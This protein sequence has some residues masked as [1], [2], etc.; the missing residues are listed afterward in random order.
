M[1]LV[2]TVKVGKDFYVNDQRWL[3]ESADGGEMIALQCTDLGVRGEFKVGHQFMLAGHENVAV[4]V[5][6][7]SD[8][9][10]R[11]KIKAPR[12]VGIWRGD[13]YRKMHGSKD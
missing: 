8:F 7:C 9:S 4:Q 12:E 3:L 10:C 5:V 1:G 2:L 11:L 6:S 13:I